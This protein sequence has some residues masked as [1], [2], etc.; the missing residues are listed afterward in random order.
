V[1]P[2]IVENHGDNDTNVIFFSVY[3]ALIWLVI[4]RGGV[5]TAENHGQTCEQVP[6][7]AATRHEAQV[8]QQ[9]HDCTEA[10]QD[11]H[12]IRHPRRTVLL[13]LGCRRRV[14]AG[15]GHVVCGV[16][17]RGVVVGERTLLTGFGAFGCH[18]SAALVLRLSHIVSV[19][20]FP[21]SSL[22]RQA[23]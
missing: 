4:F 13:E 2:Q 17:M 9:N 20:G 5:Q 18:A 7:R 11:E 15:G 16:H 14:A 6:V 23:V 3:L 10:K 21:V 19:I 8:V 12:H 1:F 22:S